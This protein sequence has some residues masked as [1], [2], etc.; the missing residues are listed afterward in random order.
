MYKISQYGWAKYFDYV[1]IDLLILAGSFFATFCFRHEGS[2]PFLNRDYVLFFV[3]LL[4]LDLLVFIIFDNLQGILSRGYYLELIKTCEHTLLLFALICAL[5]FLFQRGKV[6]SRLT[7]CGMLLIYILLSYLCRLIW[8]SFKKKKQH[9]DRV[10]LLVITDALLAEGLLTMTRKNTGNYRIT[11]LIISDDNLTGEMIQGIPVVASMDDT[12]DYISQNW[13]DEVLI[14]SESNKYFPEKMISDCVNMGVTVHINMV[15]SKRVMGCKQISGTVAG[16][17]VTTFSLN[18]MTPG[19]VFLKRFMDICGGLAGC[20]ATGI[21]Y[22]FLAPAIKLESPGPVFFK[23][24]RIGLNGKPFT[25]YKFRSM[26]TDAEERKKELMA[27]NEMSGLMFKMDFDP[28]VIGNKIVNG[29][30]KTGIGEFIRKHSLDEFPQFFNVL[31]G[32]MSLVGTRPP[33]VDEFKLYEAHHRTRLATVPGITGLWQISG[34]SEIKDFEEI[35][36]LDTEYI[37]TWNFGKDIRI[38]FRT[39]GMVFKPKGAV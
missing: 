18:M 11:G 6:Y 5:L 33:T 10:S 29:E 26:Y 31:K 13:V 34:R 20:V 15:P 16:N 3:L 23:Q 38:I 12:I 9:F 14:S 21:L 35:V 17:C 30:E 32:D 1:I 19:Q 39:I 27:Q 36:K 8:R 37:N 24:T 4:L 7:V 2:N 22:L 25:M 28:R